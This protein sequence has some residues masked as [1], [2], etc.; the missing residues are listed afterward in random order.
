MDFLWSLRCVQKLQE[1]I[2]LCNFRNAAGYLENGLD[3]T[4]LTKTTGEGS[5]WRN[6]SQQNHSRTSRGEDFSILGKK[7]DFWPHSLQVSEV[8]LGDRAIFIG[9]MKVD[10]FRHSEK[11]YLLFVHRSSLAQTTETVRT[12]AET[13]RK[14]AG[15]TSSTARTGVMNQPPE[16]ELRPVVLFWICLPKYWNL[17][18]VMNQQQSGGTSFKCLLLH[19]TQVSAIFSS[20]YLLSISQLILRNL[21]HDPDTSKS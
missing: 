17:H 13:E 10:G 11:S 19:L 20:E 15:G 16:T 21:Q 12:S 2:L 7:Q 5:E 18:F 9:I 3:T 4:L 6:L 1:I 14:W 8:S